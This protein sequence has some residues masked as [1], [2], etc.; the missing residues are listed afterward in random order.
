MHY[1]IDYFIS[2]TNYSIVGPTLSAWSFCYVSCRLASL[3]SMESVITYASSNQGFKR[4][5]NIASFCWAASIYSFNALVSCSFM[6]LSVRETICAIHFTSSYHYYSSHASVI[7]IAHCSLTF[8]G[9]EGW[10]LKYNFAI[11][12]FNSNWTFANFVRASHNPVVSLR[13]CTSTD[14][15]VGMANSGTI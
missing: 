4:A 9:V 5:F 14:S 2:S 6:S 7:L 13:M 11:C 15:S 10:V 1:T 3:S 12:R 8:G